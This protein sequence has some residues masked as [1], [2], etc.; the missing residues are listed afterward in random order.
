MTFSL[1]SPNLEC[2]SCKENS[3]CVLKEQVVADL[4]SPSSKSGRF[5]TYKTAN[6][7]TWRDRSTTCYMIGL[8]TCGKSGSSEKRGVKVKTSKSV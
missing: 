2:S 3:V 1:G 5:S 7:I 6:H 8:L 4:F